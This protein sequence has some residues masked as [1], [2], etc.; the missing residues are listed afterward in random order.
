MPPQ[1]RERRPVD[2]SGAH[3]CQ[4]GGDN[5]DHTS[6]VAISQPFT[7]IQNAARA[8]LRAA[9]AGDVKLTWKGSG[10]AGQAS[11]ATEPL[12]DSQIEWLSALLARAGLAPLSDE[13]RQ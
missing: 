2:P 8:L 1:T 12:S 13:V 5:R 6:E 4:L 11:L 10:F 7:S 3:D 9:W